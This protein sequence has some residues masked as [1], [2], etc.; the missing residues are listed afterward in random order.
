MSHVASSG[1]MREER[2]HPAQVGQPLE[3]PPPAKGGRVWP[4]R[5]SRVRF[6]QQ[7]SDAGRGCGNAPRRKACSL[8]HLPWQYSISTTICSEANRF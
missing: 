1:N 3:G 5:F 6:V 7:V 8:G 2:I 4:H